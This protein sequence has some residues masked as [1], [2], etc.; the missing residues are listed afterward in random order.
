MKTFAISCLMA[1]AVVA[2][3]KEDLMGQLPFT[4]AFDSPSYSGYIAASETKNLHY[5]FTESLDNPKTDPVLIWFNGG[6]GC[7]SMLGFI[8]ENGPRVVNDGE[9]FLI[10][11][12]DTWNN[13]ANVLWLESPAG[14]G[15]ST[16]ATAADL[17]TDDLQQ[18]IDALAA[19]QSWYVKVPEFKENELYISGESYAGIYVPYLSYQIDLNNRKA[20]YSPMFEKINLKG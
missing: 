20:D 7:S 14:V 8:Q 3:P 19:L 16:G 4:T 11:N 18:S 13:K 12:K 17:K 1:V 2:A 9:D 5:V 10:E 6:P 15:W